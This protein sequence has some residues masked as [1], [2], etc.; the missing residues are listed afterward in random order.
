MLSGD[1]R[2]DDRKPEPGV[3]AD[4]RGQELARY[5][6]NGQRT[7]CDQPGEPDHLDGAARPRERYSPGS[8][9][10]K[11]STA[12]SHRRAVAGATAAAKTAACRPGV[13]D[14]DHGGYEY[15]RAVHAAGWTYPN[16]PRSEERRVGK[17]CRYR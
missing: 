11:H 12:I 15:R 5:R 4:R 8:F 2:K 16:Q 10:G 1:G 7:D 3:G 14:Q 9:R 17:E 6:G 13:A